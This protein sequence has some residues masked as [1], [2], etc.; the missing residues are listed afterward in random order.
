MRCRIGNK[1]I[2]FHKREAPL[3][4]VNHSRIK[5]EKKLRKGPWRLAETTEEEV[6]EG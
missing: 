4:N 2:H 5:L 3:L 1:V 6:G